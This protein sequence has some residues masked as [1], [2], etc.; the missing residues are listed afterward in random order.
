MKTITQTQRVF[1]SVMAV[2]FICLGV[3]CPTGVPRP[4]A[5]AEGAEK[6]PHS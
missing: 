6:S 2:A 3:G 1:V 4:L 5:S